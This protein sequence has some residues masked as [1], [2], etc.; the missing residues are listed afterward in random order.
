MTRNSLHH[1]LQVVALSL[2]AAQAIAWGNGGEDD[3]DVTS[4]G[5]S[6]SR[7]WLYDSSSLSMKLEGCV[8]GYVDDNED[9]G[10]M[11]DSSE[12]GTTY[13][14]QMANCRR[15]Q[16]VYSIYGSS[17]SSSGCNSGNF[18]E[19]VSLIMTSMIVMSLCY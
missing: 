4:F 19:T 11:E 13:W 5:N 2:L 7:D 16:A 3:V 10:C 1:G 9:S 14:Y 15:A 8:W 6:M 12:D 18:K 17:S